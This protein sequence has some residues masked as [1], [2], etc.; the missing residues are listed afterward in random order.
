[1]R[2]LERSLRKLPVSGTG[3][4]LERGVNLERNKF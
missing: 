2:T 1:L 4:R 3:A